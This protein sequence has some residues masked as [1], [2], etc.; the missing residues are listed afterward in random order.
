MLPY[1]WVF[2]NRTL[3]QPAAVA[4]LMVWL[5]GEA[6]KDVNGAVIPVYGADV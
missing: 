4:S 6:A 2:V 1:L 3:V 5:A